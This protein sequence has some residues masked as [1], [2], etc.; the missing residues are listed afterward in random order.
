MDKLII[1]VIWLLYI[2]YYFSIVFVF[3]HYITIDC[4]IIEFINGEYYLIG[5]CRIDQNIFAKI[6]DS[7]LA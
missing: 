6:T 5:G 1:I 4:F 7:C 3:N 2:I